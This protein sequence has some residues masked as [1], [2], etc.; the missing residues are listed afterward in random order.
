ME[1][2]VAAGVGD[3]AGQWDE[4]VGQS[5]VPT[6]FLSSWW[7]SGMAD[8]T[9]VF[10]LAREDGHF[11][12]G[13]ALQVVPWAGI[14]LVQFRGGG[15][16]EP[17][18]LDVVAVPGAHPAVADAVLDWLCRRSSR[19]VRLD[20]M[21]DDSHMVAALRRRGLPVEPLVVAPCA[22]LSGDLDAY[23]A[24][25]PGSLR[26]DVRRAER[27]M[28]QN[29][30]TFRLAAD[31]PSALSVLLDLHADQ[32]AGWS[33]LLS[34]RAA[35]ERAVAAG[36]RAGQVAIGEVVSPSG[37]VLAA[38]LVLRAGSRLEHY[39]GGRRDTPQARG[40]GTWLMWHL[41]VAHPEVRELDLLRG[42]EGYK[43]R[44]AT[45]QRSLVTSRFGV[46]ALARS[47]VSASR[48]RAEGVRR[49]QA[50]RQS[51]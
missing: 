6:A 34:A 11:V 39:Q 12:G 51:R 36:G 3:L 33:Q 31:I 15:A 28:A 41:L 46:G 26:R 13:A 1:L 50:R 10:L 7:L 40:A 14:D 37:E 29:G 21:D 48:I 27:T 38:Q 30:N 23:M 47:L 19:A 5:A 18:H 44:W 4:L 32:W 17:D 22:S 42:G 43:D 20:G 2:V 24:A 8:G 25:R 49:M 45:G 35:L 9:P 16:L